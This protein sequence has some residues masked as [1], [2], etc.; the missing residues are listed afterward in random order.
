MWPRQP[1]FDSWCGHFRALF[2]LVSLLLAQTSIPPARIPPTRIPSHLHPTCTNSRKCGKAA[3]ESCGLSYGYIAQWLERLTADQQVPGSNPGVPF[4][5]N[6]SRTAP[7]ACASRAKRE[8]TSIRV[9][10]HPAEN[11]GREIRTPNLLIWSQT[12]CR[13][14]I[15]PMRSCFSYH[16]LWKQTSAAAVLRANAFA[17]TPVILRC[18]DR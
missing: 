1:R 8:H 2:R 14:A 3:I 6:A 9:Q 7:R 10:N 16:T 11:E 13:C 17:T 12:R 15:P 5:A 4:Y 18:C